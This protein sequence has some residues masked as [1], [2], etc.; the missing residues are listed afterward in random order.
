MNKV[1]ALN[2]NNSKVWYEAAILAE[3]RCEYDTAQEY[4]HKALQLDPQNVEIHY[5]FSM[6]LISLKRNSEAI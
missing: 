6:I 1:L 4:L 5:K 2:P 3:E